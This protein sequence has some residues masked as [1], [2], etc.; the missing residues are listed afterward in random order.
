MAAAG[1]RPTKE[2][3]D[4]ATKPCIGLMSGCQFWQFLQMLSIFFLITIV[5]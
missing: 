4:T 3:A 5:G 2:M 1:G